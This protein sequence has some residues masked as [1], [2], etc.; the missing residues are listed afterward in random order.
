M[1][2]RR[3]KT[4][5]ASVLRRGVF[6]ERNSTCGSARVD[7]LCSCGWWTDNS[8]PASLYIHV[9]KADGTVHRVWPRHIPGYTCKRVGMQGRMHVAKLVWLYD[10]NAEA[11]RTPGAENNQKGQTP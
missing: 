11:H 9:R 3:R 5:M 8:D 7:D 2:M 10:A 1:A 6:S 4:A